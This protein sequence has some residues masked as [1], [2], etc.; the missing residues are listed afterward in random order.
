MVAQ[1]GHA[2]QVMDAVVPCTVRTARPED[3][4][5]VLQVYAAEREPE[6]GSPRV[7]SDLEQRTWAR[8]MRSDDLTVYL[9]EI[10][11]QVV[12]TATLMTM[13]NLTYGCAPTAFVEAVVVAIGHRRTGVATA[14]MRRLLGDAR[15][16]GCNKVQLLSHKRH[17]VDGAHRL[18]TSLGFE[19]EAEGFRLYLREVPAAVRAAKAAQR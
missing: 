3:L 6:D 17:A 1:D 18:Y 19:P 10:D 15:S 8:M 2:D 9:A 16:A 7:V 4:L 12:G 5:A 13:P 14:I 11:E